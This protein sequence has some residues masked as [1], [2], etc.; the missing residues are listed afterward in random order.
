MGSDT[1]DVYVGDDRVHLRVHQKLLCQDGPVFDKMFNGGFTE[2][3][4]KSAELPEDDPDAFDSFLI[5]LYHDR[6]TEVD[7]AVDLANK[8]T[9][10]GQL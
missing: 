5:W 8:G 2:A 6:L 1:V 4:S 3:A 10:D 7:L 9:R